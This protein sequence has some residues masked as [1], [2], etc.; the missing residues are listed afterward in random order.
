M[1]ATTARWRAPATK[2]RSTQ[3]LPACADD[4]KN[5]EFSGFGDSSVLAY[6]LLRVGD[7]SSVKM[8]CRLRRAVGWRRELRKEHCCEKTIHAAGY[9]VAVASYSFFSN[10]TARRN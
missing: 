10:C 4:R 9:R 8:R 2:H 1:P 5:A 7:H 3:T 6:S